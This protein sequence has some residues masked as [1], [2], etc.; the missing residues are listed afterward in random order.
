MEMERND[1]YTLVSAIAIG[2]NNLSNAELAVKADKI[3][4]AEQA[5]TVINHFLEKDSFEEMVDFLTDSF[6]AMD[7]EGVFGIRGTKM[8]ATSSKDWVTYRM[9]RA[10]KFFHRSFKAV[11]I[12]VELKGYNP[13]RIEEVE[14]KAEKTKAG[15]LQA[16][17]LDL[18]VDR[19]GVDAI[20]AA[21]TASEE[22][23]Y[24]RQREAREAIRIEKK[25]AQERERVAALNRLTESILDSGLT[26]E[27]LNRI[28]ASQKAVGNEE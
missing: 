21:F 10:A 28:L 11:N 22:R 19:I 8:S 3:R 13:F 17:A 1:L 24:A 4:L 26:A 14:E 27:D 7:A 18:G 15:K 2:S 16:F 25:A 9:E 12:G 5:N 20:L 23:A 6:Q